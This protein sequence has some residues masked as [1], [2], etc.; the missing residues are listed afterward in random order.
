MDTGE[1][2]PR[3][4]PHNLGERGNHVPLYSKVSGPSLKGGT[5]PNGE[6]K[7]K[8]KIPNVFQR[9]KRLARMLKCEGEKKVL[10]PI[11]EKKRKGSLAKKRK[12]TWAMIRNKI[13]G[14]ILFSFAGL[15]PRKLKGKKRGSFPISEEEKGYS[16]Y[17][18]EGIS[19]LG[20]KEKSSVIALC[21]K[22]IRIKR[23]K[24]SLHNTS[25]SRKLC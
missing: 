20:P 12:A 25:C 16:F 22:V 9:D 17:P 6:T 13:K 19:N 7:K 5:K 2:K 11:K 15:G 4:R 14:K 1:E 24:I 3:A 10:L 21:S 8:R 18:K 23:R